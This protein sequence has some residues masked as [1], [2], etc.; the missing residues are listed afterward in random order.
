MINEM[1]EFMIFTD[2]MKKKAKLFYPDININDM[3]DMFMDMCETSYLEWHSQLNPDNY[4]MRFQ[5]PGCVL[6]NVRLPLWPQWLSRRQ[7]E[8]GGRP[9][10]PN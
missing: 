6:E 5:W 9:W 2:E 8:A 1:R 10:Q 4:S 3:W 7:C